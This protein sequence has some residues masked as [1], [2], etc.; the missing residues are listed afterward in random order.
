MLRR[1]SRTTA[2]WVAF[3]TILRDASLP[4]EDLG[5]A[6]QH[7]FALGA[8]KAFGGY[9]LAGPDA[10]LRS[11]AVPPQAQRRG[12]GRAMVMAL[13]KQ[14]EQ[15]GVKRAW[16]FTAA[17]APFFA[18]IGF[19]SADRQSAPAA[20]SATPQF[21]GICPSGATFMCRPLSAT[22]PNQEVPA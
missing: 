10:L 16:L 5:C 2:E 21:Q 15:I 9:F 8:A 11:V 13:L 17:A 7:Y 4:T 22:S 6:G 12:L 3:E 18:R 19:V 20:I 14:L 1:L